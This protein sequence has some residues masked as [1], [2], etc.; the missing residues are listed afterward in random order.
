MPVLTEKHEIAYE[1][2]QNQQLSL[3]CPDYGDLGAGNQLKNFFLDY[4]ILE[5]VQIETQIGEIRFVGKEK[6]EVKVEIYQ[7][8]RHS[9]KTVDAQTSD[10]QN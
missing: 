8:K 2:G 1:I 7:H 3:L 9:M 5:K 4:F 10:A 6:K